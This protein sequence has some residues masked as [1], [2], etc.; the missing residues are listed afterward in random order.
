MAIL[1]VCFLV[2]Q[3]TGS[4][5]SE[6]N[7]VESRLDAKIE[8]E[9]ARLESRIDRVESKLETKIDGVESRLPDSVG[10]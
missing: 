1:T 6:L 10:S 9:V 5:R 4:T 8:S 7:R 2:I 3:Q